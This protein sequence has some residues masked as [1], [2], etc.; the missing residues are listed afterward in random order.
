MPFRDEQHGRRR[1]VVV[2]S[3]LAILTIGLATV[4]IRFV[5]Y[6]HDQQREACARAMD[7]RQGQRTMWEYAIETASP[8]TPEAQQ[9]IDDFV[10]EL[11][12][13]LPPYMCVDNVPTPAYP[14]DPD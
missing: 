7:A 4:T 2:V 1:F 10:A 5:D 8:D 12:K 13:R 9:R 11:N 14:P 6:R 3:L